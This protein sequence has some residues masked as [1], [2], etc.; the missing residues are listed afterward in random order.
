MYNATHGHTPRRTLHVAA[1]NSVP[2]QPVMGVDR[3]NTVA[4]PPLLEIAGLHKW[5]G[6][7]HVLRGIDLTQSRGEIVAI[8]GPSG[9]GKSTLLRCINHLER[10]DAGS[11]HLDGSLVGYELKHDRLYHQREPDLARLRQHIGMVFQ[12]FNLF[13]HMTAVQNVCYGQV[14]IQKASKKQATELAMSLL[15]QVGLAD[16]YDAY[17]R[18][19]SGGQQQR[20]AIARALA[21]QPKLMLFDEPT[22]ALDAEL[23]GEVLAVI[24]AL[25]ERG[26]TMLIVTHEIAFARE[27]ADRIIVM[28]DGQIAA[29]GT[30]KDVLDDSDDPG[31]SRFLRR[32]RNQAGM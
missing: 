30:P 12:H 4:L 23:V 1:A 10:R 22:S 15:D 17:P 19:L 5:Y 25:A 20:V 31:V 8:I 3:E 29:Q 32:I 7:L 24:R 6:Q 26:M 9:S 28:M 11:V 18:Q 14:R 13:G 27:V 16:K 2:R 21:L